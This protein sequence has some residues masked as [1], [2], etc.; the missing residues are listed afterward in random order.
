MPMLDL[1]IITGAGHG[2]GASIAGDACLYARTVIAIG[3]SAAVEAI[4][5]TASTDIR[6][7]RIDLADP[8]AAEERVK[9]ELARIEPRRRVGLALCA[10]QIGSHGGL[11]TAD[12]AEWSRLFA[13]NV[14]GN[15]AVVKA[16]LPAVVAG[17]SLR[18]VFFGGGGAADGYPEFSAYAASKA[19]IVRAVENLAMEFGAKRLDAAAV[20][21]APGAIETGMLATVIAHGGTIRTKTDISEP[22]AFTRRFL[23]DEID[24]RGLNGRFVHVRD[25]LLGRDFTSAPEA[26]FKLRRVE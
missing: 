19:A 9:K 4:P 20:V 23:N 8:A 18:A 25:D 1:A 10:A 12:F 7:I 22:T 11:E 16:C 17:G 5:A 26:L 3:F 13:I 15:L 24:A 6:R 2:V 14:L 21:L